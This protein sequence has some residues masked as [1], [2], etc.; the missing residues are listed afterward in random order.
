MTGK[1]LTSQVRWRN[2]EHGVNRCFL[3]EVIHICLPRE[4]VSTSLDSLSVILGTKQGYCR[5]PSW[6]MKAPDAHIIDHEH[7]SQV[8]PLLRAENSCLRNNSKGSD[9]FLSAAREKRKLELN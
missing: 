3:P 7:D 5:G 9:S 8:R 2:S 1:S 4:P 6:S